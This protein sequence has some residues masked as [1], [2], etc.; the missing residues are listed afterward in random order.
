[1]KSIGNANTKADWEDKL[2]KDLSFIKEKKRYPLSKKTLQPLGLS[3]LIIVVL[4]QVMYTLVFSGKMPVYIE[5]VL[6][7]N[8]ILL[9]GSIAYR[10]YKI[11]VFETIQT[12]E[13]VTE[14]IQLLQQ[15]FKT[16]N[17]AFT[18]HKDAPEVL[19]IISRNLDTNPNKEYRE[20]MVFIA[21]D[22]QILVN[23]HFTGSKFSFAPPSGNYKKMAKQLR[24]W[25]AENKTATTTAVVK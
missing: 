13:H 10:Y 15:F 1:M 14:N 11:L 23:S 6:I 8:T 24:N 17:L 22:K 19:M 12:T 20:V 3:I 4:A 21:D 25:L 7:I 2:V 9:T 5:W 18:R 16:Q